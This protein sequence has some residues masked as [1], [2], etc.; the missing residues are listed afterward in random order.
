MPP[1]TLFREHPE[2]LEPF[3]TGRPD[4]LER[5]YRTYARPVERFIRALAAASS[6]GAE[7]VQPSAVA[8]LVQDVF[9][10]AFSDQARQAYDGVRDYAPYL[11]TIARHCVVDA[12]RARRRETLVDPR[13]ITFEIDDAPELDDGVDPRVNA[14][15]DEYLRGLSP[16]LREL[17]RQRF[18]FDRSQDEAS[19]ALGISRRK[20]R[21]GEEQLRQGLRMALRR[22]GISLPDLGSRGG[23]LSASPSPLLVPGRART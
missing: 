7:A 11:T 8:D 9:I 10:R 1:P 3:R 14:V 22:A 23:G 17:Y 15:L 20:V 5:V 18:A 19:A 6:A 12:I 13:E 16:E 2:L 21:D 4:V